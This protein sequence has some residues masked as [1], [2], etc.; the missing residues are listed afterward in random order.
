MT[1]EIERKWL[2]NEIP[3]SLGDYRHEEFVQAY[4]I[5]SDNSCLR[6]RKSKTS[7]YRDWETNQKNFE[8][9]WP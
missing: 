6:I 8:W 5:T 7:P 4:L 9:N 2:V 1:Y 3:F